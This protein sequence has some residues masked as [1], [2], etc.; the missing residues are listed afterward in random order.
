MVPAPP[1]FSRVLLLSPLAH[2][3]SGGSLHLCIREILSESMRIKS[4][5]RDAS[6]SSLMHLL[7]KQILFVGID[8]GVP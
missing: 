3:N 6:Q 8:E 7:Q 1:A 4:S 5:W 2:L